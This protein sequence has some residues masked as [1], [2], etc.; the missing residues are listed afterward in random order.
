V[1]S[2]AKQQSPPKEPPVI[3]GPGRSRYSMAIISL[4]ITVN[5]VTQ[6]PGEALHLYQSL[7]IDRQSSCLISGSSRFR[8]TR[9]TTRLF[10]KE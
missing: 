1:R 6:I 4:V 9:S 2:N 5:G 7:L 3:T 10:L 8:F